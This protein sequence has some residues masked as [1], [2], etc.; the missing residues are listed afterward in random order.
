M[1]D[2]IDWR[3]IEDQPP[4]PGEYQPLALYTFSI[5][6]ISSYLLEIE[7]SSEEDAYEQVRAMNLDRLPGAPDEYIEIDLDDIVKL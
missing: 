2:R 1:Y 6:R 4:L 3:I 7:A 5:N